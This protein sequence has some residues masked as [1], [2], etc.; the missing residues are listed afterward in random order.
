[1]AQSSLK[2]VSPHANGL[3][4]AGAEPGG[5]KV[6]TN[7]RTL[8]DVADALSAAAEVLETSSHDNSHRINVEDG[9]DLDDEVN[10][11]ETELIRRALVRT[12][13]NQK[14]ASALLGLKPT[15]LNTKIKKFGINLDLQA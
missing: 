10:R 5:E 15:T 8:R 7:I 3:V 1:M 13:G 4:A 11:F 14:R 2:I 12:H 9:I 6:E